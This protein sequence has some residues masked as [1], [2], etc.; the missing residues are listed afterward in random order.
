MPAGWIA[1]H[2]FYF[3]IEPCIDH[4]TANPQQHSEDHPMVEAGDPVFDG[5]ACQPADE[6]HQSLENAKMP[7]QAEDL[8]QVVGFVHRA[9]AQAD[10]ER[11]HGKADGDNEGGEQVH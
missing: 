6:S 4:L 10:R 11:I 3:R 2:F 7:G 8:P 9:D 1:W 5:A